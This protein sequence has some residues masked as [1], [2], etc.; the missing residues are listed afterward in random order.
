MMRERGGR[1]KGQSGLSGNR[2]PLKFR[3]SRRFDRALA[4][5]GSYVLRRS[6]RGCRYSPGADSLVR[7]AMGKTWFGKQPKPADIAA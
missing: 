6:V 4:S 2:A 3:G 5:G 1:L 7:E